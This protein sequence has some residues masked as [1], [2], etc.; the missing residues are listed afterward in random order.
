M[1]NSCTSSWNILWR[2]NMTGIKKKE[3]FKMCFLSL[4]TE[5]QENQRR[6]DSQKSMWAVK[7]NSQESANED[8]YFIRMC[9][10]SGEQ[11]KE[12][13]SVTRSWQKIQRE[14]K[15]ERERG[16][17]RQDSI[18]ILWKGLTIH[19]SGLVYTWDDNSTDLAKWRK[20]RKHMTNVLQHA[21]LPCSGGTWLHIGTLLPVRVQVQ[22]WAPARTAQKN[23]RYAQLCWNNMRFLLLMV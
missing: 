18:Q 3:K 13:T 14:R 21:A 22:I 15:R 10:N 11:K 4:N 8:L 16:R 12:V 7:E 9:W 19:H 1:H 23:Y 20:C 6:E 17:E 2:R 5:S